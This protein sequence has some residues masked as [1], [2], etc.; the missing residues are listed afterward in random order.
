MGL[1]PHENV[2]KHCFLYWIWR[3]WRNFC[4][5]QFINVP[6]SKVHVTFRL[7]H[8]RSGAIVSFEGSMA[9]N[10][11]LNISL[12]AASKLPWARMWQNSEI[13]EIIVPNQNLDMYYE[14][15]PLFSVCVYICES[16]PVPLPSHP[17]VIAVVLSGACTLCIRDFHR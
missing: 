12:V 16:S 11:Q 17:P 7:H 6:Q 3:H 13:S 5:I 8:L 9:Q 2:M 4:K 15:T 10:Q 14:K 1:H